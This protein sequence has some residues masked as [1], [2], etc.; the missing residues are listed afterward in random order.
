MVRCLGGEM[1]VIDGL[2]KAIDGRGRRGPSPRAP[3]RRS[4]GETQKRTGDRGG[5]GGMAI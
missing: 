3:K 2:H 5:A 4:A 1:T